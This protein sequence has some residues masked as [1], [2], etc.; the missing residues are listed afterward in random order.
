MFL[1]REKEKVSFGVEGKSTHLLFKKWTECSMFPLAFLG[2]KMYHSPKKYNQ[3]FLKR[4]ADKTFKL[5]LILMKEQVRRKEWVRGHGKTKEHR[6]WNQKDLGL[7]LSSVTKM[8]NMLLK[9]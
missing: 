1:H 8:G 6:I 4:R 5:C 2:R 3:N 9:S 7:N